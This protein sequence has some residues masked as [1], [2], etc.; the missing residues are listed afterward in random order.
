MMVAM[1][2]HVAILKR[3]YIA[4]ILDGRKVIESRLSKVACPPFDCIE[5]DERVYLK[6]SGGPFAARAVAG[7]VITHADLT[8]DD[9][10]DIEQRYRPAI[11][12]DDAYWQAKQA[13]RFGTLIRLREVEP[14]DVG[15]RFKPQNM[16]AWY[17]LDDATDPVADVVLTAGALRNGYV[18]LPR[19][20]V[21]AGPRQVTLIMP[22]GQR[23]A[24]DEYRGQQLRWRGW[25]RYFQAFDLHPG[26]VVRFIAIKPGEYAVRLIRQGPVHS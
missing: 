21:T 19:H 6:V 10:R 13:A 17:V 22:D 7:D 26:D 16:R 8:P 12:G 9:V 25:R 2:V 18:R 4:M 11:G 14:I 15:P 24:T 20:S 1:A 23:I 5:P 3:E